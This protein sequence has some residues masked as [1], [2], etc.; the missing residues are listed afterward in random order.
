[1]NHNF[2]A[3]LTYSVLQKYHSKEC[4][5]EISMLE[6]WVKYSMTGQNLT[7]FLILYDP[8]FVKNQKT[9]EVCLRR[10]SRLG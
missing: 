9:Q 7:I 4:L 10:R 3:H 6:N 1:M 8:H 5:E 2:L